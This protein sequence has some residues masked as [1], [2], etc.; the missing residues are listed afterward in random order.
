MRMRSGIVSF[1]FSDGV[2]AAVAGDDLVAGLRQQ[3]VQHVPF[4]RRVVDDEYLLDRHCGLPVA[5]WRRAA[6]ARRRRRRPDPPSGS[7]ASRPS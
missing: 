7:R 5:W 3:V 6:S 1:A 2:V 4:G